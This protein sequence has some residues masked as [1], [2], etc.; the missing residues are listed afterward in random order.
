M[1][2]LHKGAFSAAWLSLDKKE[3]R[4]LCRRPRKVTLMFPKPLQGA[5]ELSRNISVTSILKTK[6]IQTRC[7]S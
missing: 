7:N 6:A 1:E 2:V 4:A 3:V 5:F